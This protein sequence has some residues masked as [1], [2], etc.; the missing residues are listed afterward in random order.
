LNVI[1]SLNRMKSRAPGIIL[2]YSGTYF[3]IL[4][5]LDFLINGWD[6]DFFILWLI[7][8]SVSVVIVD[9]SNNRKI[10]NLTTVN[11]QL[12]YIE[13]LT[14]ALRTSTNL[15]AVLGLVLKNLT[16]ELKYD[17]VLIFS[18]ETDE[19]KKELLRPAAAIGIDF[20]SVKNFTF[21]LDKSLDMVPRV[22]IE[23]TGYIIKN[24]SDDYRCS[25]VFVNL[26][27]LKEYIVL[28][29]VVKNV[30]VGVLLADNVVNKKR[31][32]EIDLVP[33]TSFAN[34]VAMGIE[35]AKLYQK[36]EYLAIVD[37]LTNVYNHRYFLES[38]REEL[39]RM[40]RYEK[41][42]MLS[43]IMLDV[44]HFKAYNDKNGHMAG[45]AVLVEIG[46]ILKSLCRQ[47]DVVARYGGEEFIIMLPA[48][49]KDGAVILAERIRKEIEEYAF[50]FRA[51]QPG[52]RL[53]VSL[54]VSAFGPDGKTPDSLIKAADSGLYEAKENGR[55]R[56]CVK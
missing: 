26:L 6:Q 8:A 10:N 11:K 38:L 2:S 28:P 1:D 25:Q 29:L 9:I 5:G 34:Q 18:L 48:T 42:G 30:A 54:G 31:I 50:E 12:H 45:D 41:D 14:Q 15:N 23:R 49:G 33:L 3:L 19:N 39:A 32:E 47:V 22:A 27:G 35:N 4:L 37:G 16:E 52:G 55:N 20:E 56:V 53:T 46:Q 21:K 44:D 51:G 43:I 7:I 24:A 40:I 13:E 36:I 17:R